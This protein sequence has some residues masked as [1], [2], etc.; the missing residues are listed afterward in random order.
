MSFL[1]ECFIQSKD[2]LSDELGK[3]ERWNDVLLVGAN[4]LREF[5][6]LDLSQLSIL[7]SL[8][9][10]LNELISVSFGCLLSIVLLFKVFFLLVFITIV[11]VFIVADNVILINLLIALLHDE[12]CD[13]V[14]DLVAE[15]LS[16]QLRD[17]VMIFFLLD[18]IHCIHVTGNRLVILGC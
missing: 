17:E 12:V 8:L 6:S 13:S 2:M 3:L 16:D 15:V 4:S 5:P 9:P 11:V 7:L 1:G 10:C 14:K 18:V